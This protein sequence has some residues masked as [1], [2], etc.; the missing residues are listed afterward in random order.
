MVHQNHIY[1][2]KE[3]INNASVES[4][5]EDIW[6]H[7]YDV[8]QL[9][10]SFDVLMHNNSLISYNCFVRYGCI[11]KHDGHLLDKVDGDAQSMI[12]TKQQQQQKQ[13]YYAKSS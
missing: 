5:S 13:G 11:D 3:P 2:V 4:W 6:F 8:V 12:E 7:Y 1:L 9:A 10:H